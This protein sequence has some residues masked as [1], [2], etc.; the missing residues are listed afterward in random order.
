MLRRRASPVKAVCLSSHVRG[1]V[2]SCPAY[3]R[4][5]GGGNAHMC[6]RYTENTETWWDSSDIE[7]RHLIVWLASC[8]WLS[9]RSL[10]YLPCCSMNMQVAKN[11]RV[12]RILHCTL[13]EGIRCAAICWGP[14]CPAPY[15]SDHAHCRRQG[16]R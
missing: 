9:V 4:W 3:R 11:A 12:H 2:G 10:L 16:F 7:S 8:S 13:P 15:I 5:G 14:C 1:L 6:R